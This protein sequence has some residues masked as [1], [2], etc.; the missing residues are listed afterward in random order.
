MTKPLVIDPIVQRRMAELP[1]PQR[2]E[3]LLAFFELTQTF[4]QPHV[5]TGLG[6]RK[7]A[8]GVCECRGNLDLRFVFRDRTEGLFVFF[9]GDH[10]E[11]RALCRSGKLY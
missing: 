4:G 5:H 9:L 2:V 1:K 7:L 3:C 6:I 11:V 10:N 8:P